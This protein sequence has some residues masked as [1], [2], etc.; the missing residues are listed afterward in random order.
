MD[1]STYFDPLYFKDLGD[2][3]L[4]HMGTN[5]I[6]CLYPL[7]SSERTEEAASGKVVNEYEKYTVTVTYDIEGNKRKNPHWVREY[8]EAVS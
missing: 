7:I 6:Y 3:L 2:K 5:E 4:M 8:K 1:N